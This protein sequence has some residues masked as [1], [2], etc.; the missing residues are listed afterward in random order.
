[1]D[2]PTALKPEFVMKT[3]RVA[4]G[5]AAKAQLVA[6]SQLELVRFVQELI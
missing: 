1:M 2:I 4:P 5:S 3:A 6:V